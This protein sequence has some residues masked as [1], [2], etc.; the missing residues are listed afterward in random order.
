MDKGSSDD[1]NYSDSFINDDDK[2]ACRSHASSTD[3]DE[4]S[5][6]EWKDKKAKIRK[7]DGKGG[8]LRKKYKVSDSESA[9]TLAK[10]DDSSEGD[11]VEVSKD[12]LKVCTEIPLPS[13]ITR[14]KARSSSLENDQP[15]SQC[16]KTSEA[17]VHS[18]MTLNK[19]EDKPLADVQLSPLKKV[20]ETVSKKRRKKEKSN[21]SDVI[22]VDDG[23]GKQMPESVQVEKA[24][25]Y[26]VIEP[27][28]TVLL[29]ENGDDATPT[30][31]RRKKN[32][33]ED[34]TTNVQENLFECL[35]KNKQALDNKNID[36]EAVT[37]KSLEPEIPSNEV[38]IEE[39][40]KGKLDGKVA[41]DGKKVSIFYTGK[42]KDTEEP[43][44]SNL[45]ETPFRFRLGEKNVVKGL[46][47]GIKGMRVGDKRRLVIPPSLVYAEVGLN[48][49]IPKN[50][51]LVYE[52]EA[53][54][55]R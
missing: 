12:D 30:K 17:T 26:K 2:S 32:K 10:P 18:H 29:S 43:F 9:E 53:V 6:K 16:V 25:T 52:V 44:E 54:K 1:Y 14:S 27:S 22:D 49:D 51:T 33:R 55:V 42:L 8:R 40:A 38:I 3:D 21:K 50:A 15:D 13:R 48:E 35:E 24:T 20:S 7:R 41:A 31:K 19:R 34:E 4:V 36:E 45:G 47:I 37:T 23:E 11:C 28:S 46:S 39:I 5:I